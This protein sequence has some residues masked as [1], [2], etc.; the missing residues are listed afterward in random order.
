MSYDVRSFRRREEGGRGRGG[1]L[2]HAGS[3][4]GGVKGL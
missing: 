1:D 4:G 2:E 3:R